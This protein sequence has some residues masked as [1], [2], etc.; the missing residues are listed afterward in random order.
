MNFGGETR[1][2]AVLHVIDAATEQFE[3]LVHGAIEQHIVISHVEMA[4]V[5]DHAGSTRITDETKGAKNR[6][7]SSIRSSMEDQFDRRAIKTHQNFHYK[8]VR[9]FLPTSCE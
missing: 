4:V 7:T 9:I 8:S 3:G 2:L 6:G 1:V 5:I